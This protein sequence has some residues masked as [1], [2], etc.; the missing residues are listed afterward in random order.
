MT[1]PI[2]PPDNHTGTVNLWADEAIWGHRFYD[3]QTPWLVLLEFLAVF[4]SRYKAGRAFR[5]SVTGDSHERFPYYVPRLKPLRQLVFNNPH[6][7]HV[8]A[9]ETNDGAR[10]AAWKERFEWD[11]DG[12]YLRARFGDFSR[13]A[14]VCEFFRY[15]AVEPDRRRRWTSRFLFPYGTSCIYADLPGNLAGS[16]DRRFFARGGELLY[17]MLSRSH[18][19]PDLAAKIWGRLFRDDDRWNRVARSLLPADYQIDS[20]SVEI[21]NIGYL[22]FMD[23]PEYQQ[24][25]ADWHRLLDLNL[26]GTNI[27]DPL[28]RISALILLLYMIRRSHEELN[29]STEPGFVIEIAEPRKTPMIE[30]SID[31]LSGNRTLSDRAIQAYISQIVADPDCQ[32]ALSASVPAEAVRQYLLRRFYW[33]PD[34][35]SQGDPRSSIQALRSYATRRHNQHLGRVHI[36]WCRHI[37]LLA[38]RRGTGTWYSPDDA[39]LKALVL[40]TVD[41]R[42]E[43]HLFLKDLYRRYRLIVGVQEAQ[44][45]FRSLPIDEKAFAQNTQRLEQRLR[46][47]GLLRRLSDDCAYVENPFWRASDDAE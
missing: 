13:L 10:W 36:E 9:M 41:R 18:G 30:L 15:T 4:Q 7:R 19:G 17:L 5:E 35:Q 40:V 34:E 33:T 11:Y 22:P 6:L 44:H 38:S 1:E 42:Q 45:A 47:M 23:R 46:T 12:S 26:P 14:R 8:E 27:L 37:G 3:D 2:T 20:D 25:A 24:L 39:L 21:L 28:M 32:G 31:S 43:Y 29:D 16:P